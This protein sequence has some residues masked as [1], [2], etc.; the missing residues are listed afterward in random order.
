MNEPN[1]EGF[2]LELVTDS[3]WLRELDEFTEKHLN[4]ALKEISKEIEIERGANG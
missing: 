4:R 2:Q 3:S 1:I